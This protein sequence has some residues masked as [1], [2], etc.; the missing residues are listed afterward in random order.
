MGV[1]LSRR[2]LGSTM[3]CSIFRLKKTTGIQKCSPGA[4]IRMDNSGLQALKANPNTSCP[5][6][7]HSTLS[8]NNWNVVLATL[9]SSLVSLCCKLK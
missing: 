8:S 2:R 3:A 4:A 1:D 7:A 9:P 5:D 6:F